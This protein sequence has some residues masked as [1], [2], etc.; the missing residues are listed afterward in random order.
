MKIKNK[1]LIGLMTTNLLLGG[2]SVGLFEVQPSYA[3]STQSQKSIQ[4]RTQ[5]QLAVDDMV[6]VVNTNAYF[7]YASQE[8]KN[9]YEMAIGNA[10]TVLARGDSASFEE[11]KDA[12]IRINNAK[13]QVEAGVSKIIQ[14]NRLQKAI[15]DNKTQVAA[16]KTVIQN[17]PKTIERVRPQLEQI[18]KKSES[19]IAK[20]EAV[21]QTL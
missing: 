10:T 11:L 7:N 17:Y 15:N 1:L 3:A 9:A 12:T 20:A 8:S 19:L 6:N 18:I 13:Q 4:Q 2:V 21:L 16:A 14:K 5:L